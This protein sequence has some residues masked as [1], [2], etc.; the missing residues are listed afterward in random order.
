[1]PFDDPFSNLLMLNAS[2]CQTVTTD[3]AEQE[4]MPWQFN[5]SRDG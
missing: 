1:M 2:D 3:L 4:E 5:E